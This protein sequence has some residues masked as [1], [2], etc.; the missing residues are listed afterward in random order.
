V[1]TL[2]VHEQGA[3]IR[4]VQM[5]L[6]VVRGSEVLQVVRVRDLERLV[7][8]G[9]IDL[10]AS[11]MAL[12]L[13]EGIET[14]L[15]SGTGRFRGRLEPGEGKNVFLRQSQYLKHADTSF[16][17][18]HAR[19]IV[20]GKIRNARRLIYRHSRNFPNDEYG[21]TL[22]ELDASIERLAGQDSIDKILGVEGNA[23]QVYFS[24]FGSMLKG[25]LEF[26][27]RSRRPPKD[28]VNAALSFGYT[29][30]CTELVGLVAAHGLDPYVGVLHDLHYGRP[31]LALD[32]LEEFRQPAVDRL[33]LT[34]INLRVLQ[35]THFEPHG[36]TGVYLNEVGRQRFLSYYH[37]SLDEPFVCK[38]YEGADRIAFRQLMQRQ[39]LRIRQA[40][41]QDIPYE[42]YRHY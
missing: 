38:D 32:L 8:F 29:L 34:L 30:L 7:L 31:S 12:L 25:D 10:T 15:L 22:N 36:D 39:V 42:P 17:L 41:E 2:Y 20:A 19:I 23:A 9:N 14:V 5:R 40:I 35:A 1:I 11:A 16:R 3:S 37:R 21:D 28:P 24:C 27:G 33:V 6:K 13:D 26:N 18:D 4:R